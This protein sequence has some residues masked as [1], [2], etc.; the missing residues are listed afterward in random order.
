MLLGNGFN[1]DMWHYMERDVR[2]HETSLLGK[3][4]DLLLW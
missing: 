1:G 3:P 2:F 4:P